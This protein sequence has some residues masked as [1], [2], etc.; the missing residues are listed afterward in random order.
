VVTCNSLIKWEKEAATEDGVLEW[1]WN[2][3]FDYIIGNP[4]WIS[5]S[6]KQK[7]DMAPGLLEYYRSNYKGNSYLP[8]LYEYFL[9]RSL[10]LLGKG[11]SLAFV[12][13]D[14]FARNQ[15][16]TELRKYI[17]QNY[18]IKYMMFDIKFDEVVADSMAVVIENGFS[19]TNTIEVD[20]SKGKF[21]F[22]QGMFAGSRDSQFEACCLD[23][24]CDKI[25]RMKQDSVCLKEIANSFTGFICKKGELSKVRVSEEQIPVVKGTDISRYRIN[26]N[27]FYDISPENI[28]GGTRDSRKLK[29]KGKILVRKTGNKLI[30][31]I[32][33]EGYANE[34]SLYGITLKSESFRP[35]YVL[36][37]LNSKLMEEYYLNF[38]VTNINSTP[39]IKKKDLDQIPVKNCPMDVQLKIEG[40]VERLEAEFEPGI[41]EE[42]DGMIYGL[43]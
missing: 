24:H 28:I 42:L 43:Y 18:K 10:E 13:P 27:R 29:A 37:I 41:Q 1:F 32:D 31:A 9:L 35:K 21:N 17:L 25:G 36:A 39:Q 6:R 20:S 38:L 14:R 4:P 5:L 7:Q 22:E 3:K 33:T 23:D 30:A 8:N 2:N 19:V 34:Q 12:I 15:Q 16:F 26:G 40:L 11:G